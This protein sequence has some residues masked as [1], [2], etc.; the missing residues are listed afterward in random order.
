MG[1]HF[2]RLPLCDVQIGR[3][4]LHDKPKKLINISHCSMT[5]DE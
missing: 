4:L 5:N 1:A 3:T 2:R